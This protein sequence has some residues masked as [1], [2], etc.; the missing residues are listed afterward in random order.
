MIA[1]SGGDKNMNEVV[2]KAV[3][4]WPYVAKLVIYPK[5]DKELATLIFRLDE[6]LNIVGDDEKHSLITL[7]D[8][9]SCLIEDY[10]LKHHA[11]KSGKGVDALKYLMTVHKLKQ[12]DLL[13]VATQGV[14][15]D[16]LR[17]KRSLNLRQIKLL[18]K[19]FKVSPETFID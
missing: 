1:V 4:H 10:E 17:G 5:N 2:K 18:A 7:V 16:I 11:N 12:S 6:L 13:E 9:I 19:R 15:S 8:I 14:I 3:K